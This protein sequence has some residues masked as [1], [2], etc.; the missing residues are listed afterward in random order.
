LC[1]LLNEGGG[2]SDKLI[3]LQRRRGNFREYL[4]C[5][6]FHIDKGPLECYKTRNKSHERVA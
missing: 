4:G 1:L 5:A 6:N 2:D 3:N